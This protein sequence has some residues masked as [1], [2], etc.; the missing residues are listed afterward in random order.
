M[1]QYLI[2]ESINYICGDY[3]KYIINEKTTI[4]I[5]FPTDYHTKNIVF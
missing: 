4:K 2:F 1:T 3:I 5:F